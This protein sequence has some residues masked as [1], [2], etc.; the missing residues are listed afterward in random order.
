[1]N[2]KEF[3]KNYL[4][5]TQNIINSLNIKEINK[6]IDLLLL[7]RKKR[8][9]IFVMGVG[10]SASNASHFVNDLRKIGDFEA[11]S[12]T[13]NV[14]E[15]TARTND[16][17]WETIFINWLKVSK[18]RINDILIILSVGGGDKKNNVST[19]IIKALEYAKS[20]NIKSISIT[21]RKTGYAFKNSTCPILIDAN[22]PQRLTPHA[23]ELQSVIWHLIVSHPNI[24]INKT[25]WESIKNRGKK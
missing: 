18:L 6:A 7:V 3:A 4:F 1:M 8:G 12:P 22:N 13:D 9:R 20:K 11:Y 16:E 5:E 23:E 21:G 2:N 10:G 25:K 15:L 24:S 19:N 14:S 17:G